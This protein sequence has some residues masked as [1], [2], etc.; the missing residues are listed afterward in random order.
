MHCTVELE[1]WLRDVG[2]KV[3]SAFSFQQC[4]T[5]L[6]KILNQLGSLGVTVDNTWLVTIP[7]TPLK[8]K[9]EEG[10][11]PERQWP[12][13][14][15][16]L[17]WWP[18]S[19]PFDDE[20]C[21]HYEWG[22]NMLVR[23]LPSQQLLCPTLCPQKLKSIVVCWG[24]R[25]CGWFLQTLSCPTQDGQFSWLPGRRNCLNLQHGVGTGRSLPPSKF[26]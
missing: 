21:L 2:S 11:S 12:S 8:I 18:T 14:Y 26:H 19:W 13:K 25:Y 3:V 7:K 1:W 4:W 15:G 24:T 23:L 20:L 22:H 9:L 16:Y 17:C 10:L 6:G 5:G